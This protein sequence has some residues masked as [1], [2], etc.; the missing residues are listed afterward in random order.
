[1]LRKHSKSV[2]VPAMS[3]SLIQSTARPQLSVETC[4][5]LSCVYFVA[6]CNAPFWNAIL[7]NREPFSISTWL[8]AATLFIAITLLHF[9]LVAALCNRWT[10]KP[11]LIV[12]IIVTAVAVSFMQTYGV[13]IDMAMFQSIIQTDF[14]EAREYVN[15]TLAWQVLAYSVMPASLLAAIRIR[16]TPLLRAV[17]VRLA[18]LA[19]ALVV[20]GFA[21]L[22]VA[23]DLVPLMRTQKSI[24]YLLTPGNYLVAGSK[25]AF[26][27]FGAPDEARRHVAAVDEHAVESAKPDDKPVLF[28][29]VVGET[30]R[31]D[32]FSLNGYRRET[33]PRLSKLDVINF[34]DVT[35]CGTATEVSLPCMFSS[36]GRESYRAMRQKEDGLLQ[37][38]AHAGYQVHWLDNNSGCKG[39]CDDDGIAVQGAAELSQEEC[40]RGRCLDSVLLDSLR[41][42]Q[43]PANKST[44]VVL[45]SLGSHGPGYFLRY[46]PMFAKFTPTCDTTDLRACTTQQIVN[47][48]DNGILYTDYWLAELIQWLRTQEPGYRTAMLYVGDH[49]ESLGEGGIYLH[50]LPYAIAPHVQTHVP[51]ILWMAADFR[52]DFEI[53]EKCVR[54]RAQAPASHDN[55][56]HSVMGLL[57]VRN[58]QYRASRDVFAPC[59]SSRGAEIPLTSH[60]TDSSKSL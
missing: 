34:P 46:A 39:A 42:L 55:L 26:R 2:S 21:L 16:R 13:Y 4:V 25:A 48:Y 59:R 45:H 28:V 35:S 58:E 36:G 37:A 20:A 43:L 49:G 40:T 8:F 32:N 60:T 47:A 54:A 29:M 1:M 57:A 44:F 10:A 41:Q 52:Q 22:M 15:W 56:F 38:F 27:G 9:V 19:G 50:G 7:V 17:L 5:I 12:L 53:E 31:G 30:A 51:M 14:D 6:L 23:K 24:R 33:N 11:I 3:P 18:A